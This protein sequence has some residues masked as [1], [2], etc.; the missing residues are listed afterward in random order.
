MTKFT[1]HRETT[2]SKI[3]LQLES[4]QGFTYII[5]IVE[6]GV[7]DKAGL[8]VG[9]NVTSVHGTKVV[10]AKQATGVLKASTG[11]IVIEAV[12]AS[13]TTGSKSFYA[14]FKT[15]SGNNIPQASA[16]ASAPKGIPATLS[17]EAAAA[18]AKEA[19]EQKAAREAAEAQAAKKAAER[20]A[21]VERLERARAGAAAAAA[22]SAG[23][24][25]SQSIAR[26]WLTKQTVSCNVAS[27]DSEHED[28][29]GLCI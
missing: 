17:E 15:S 25:D 27:P 6:G 28:D 24:N 3:G 1:I 19:E 4:Y 10:G 9:M 16:T 22:A 13:L 7:S 5:N 21:V 20:Q 14:M 18:K 11:N 29:A 8:K 26:Q 2:T 12:N 23:S